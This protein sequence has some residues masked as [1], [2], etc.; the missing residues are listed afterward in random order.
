MPV[1]RLVAP[2]WRTPSERAYWA[3][4]A[5]VLHGEFAPRQALKP[6]GL[7][8]RYGVS[9]AVVREALLRLVG[10]GLADRLP[11]RGFAVPAVDAERW[12]QLAQARVLIEPAM[13]RMSIAL[14]DLDWEVQVRAAHHRL[15]GT[16]PYEPQ[17]DTHYSDAWAEAHRSFHRTLLQACGNGVLLDT[18]DRLWTAGELAR[19]WAGSVDP[20]RDAIGEH[21]AL[22]EAALAHDQEQAAHLL[23]QHLGSTAAVLTSDPHDRGNSRPG[24]AVSAGKASR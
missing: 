6:Q 7:A 24:P 1:D 8:D 3:L 9:L 23:A 14:G 17:D 15:A 13:L 16:P 5:A 10:E 19:R 22:E 21:R 4:R 18:F 11:N 20:G 2:E 12:Q